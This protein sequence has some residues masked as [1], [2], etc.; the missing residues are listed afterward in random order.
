VIRGS[1]IWD[2]DWRKERA[3]A[4]GIDPG[5]ELEE[6]YRKRS[7]LKLNVL[8]EDIAE[9][10]WFFASAASGK[11]TGNILNVDAGNSQAFTR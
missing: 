8:P 7:M 1:K 9:A 11:S 2:G 10:V 5:E 6:F 3:D 4:Y